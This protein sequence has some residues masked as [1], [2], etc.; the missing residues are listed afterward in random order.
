MTKT[1]FKGMNSE[2]IY[3]WAEDVGEICSSDCPRNVYNKLVV[4]YLKYYKTLHYTCL[5][6]LYLTSRPAA[7]WLDLTLV[8]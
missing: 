4:I 7:F 8:P 6:I 5:Y 1:A 2:K 3:I